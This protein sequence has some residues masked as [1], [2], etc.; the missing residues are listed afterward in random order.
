MNF[1]EST[2]GSGQ[3]NSSGQ[4]PAGNFSG[5]GFNGNS[6][7]AD[8]NSFCNTSITKHGPN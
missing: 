5:S 7:T 8:E 2:F 1:T 4:N 3:M 6:G